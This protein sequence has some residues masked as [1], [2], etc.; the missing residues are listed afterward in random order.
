MVNILACTLWSTMLKIIIDACD[1]LCPMVNLD[2]HTNTPGWF[3]ADIIEMVNQ[4]RELTNIVRKNYI[5]WEIVINLLLGR[6]NL[7]RC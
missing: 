1:L 7:G 2:I 4:K 6:K 3:M 5:V